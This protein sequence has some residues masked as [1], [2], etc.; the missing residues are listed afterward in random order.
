M[1]KPVPVNMAASVHRRLIDYAKKENQEP[2]L[3]LMRYGLERLAYRLSQSEH[4]GKFVMKGA[5]LFLVWTGEPYRA[6]K[7]LDMLAL[8][9]TSA[10]EMASIFK[11]VCVTKVVDDGLIFLPDTVRAV[12]IR[13]ELL[14]QGIRVTFDAHLGR[15]RIPLQVDV[16]FG[17]VMTPKAKTDAFPPLLDFPAARLP[18]YAPETAI[19]EKFETIVKLGLVNSRLKDYYDIQVLSREFAFQG[20][21]LSTAIKATFKRRQ[22]QLVTGV[23]LGVSDD[24]ATD[25]V[26][27]T[28][29]RAFIRRG[30]L[31]YQ[32]TN[33]AVVV[34]SVRN[35]LLPPAIA[36]ANEQAFAAEWPKG[37]PWR[38]KT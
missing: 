35:F 22:T 18:M 16:G 10:D 26:K 9:T 25:T 1:S 33:L 38:V 6:T 2:Q 31:K 23:P 19:A 36:A 13:E 8:R 37:G 20:Q 17:D 34:E 27:L 32:E 12:E 7:D 4:R 14:Y 5:M 24:F 15:A 28:Q 30:R 11:S 29:W 21:I 3:V